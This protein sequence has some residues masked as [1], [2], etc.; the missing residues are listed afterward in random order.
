MANGFVTKIKAEHECVRNPLSCRH[1]WTSIIGDVC[2]GPERTPPG[3]RWI[4]TWIFLIFMSV[5][6]KIFSEIGTPCRREQSVMAHNAGVCKEHFCAQVSRTVRLRHLTRP[7][8]LFAALRPLW[9]VNDDVLSQQTI[10]LL[11]T[12]FSLFVRCPVPSRR[13][14]SLGPLCRSVRLVAST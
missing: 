11:N 9:L 2:P 10:S 1:C 8:C 5:H 12:S 4:K 7:L 6:S 14:R 13:T 3:G